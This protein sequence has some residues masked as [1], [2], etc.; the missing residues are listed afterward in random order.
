MPRASTLD[1]SFSHLYSSSS[2]LFVVYSRKNTGRMFSPTGGSFFCASA[3]VRFRYTDSG[4]TLIPAKDAKALSSAFLSAGATAPP[5][6]DVDDD[7]GDDGEDGADLDDGDDGDDGDDEPL[8]ADFVEV[9]ASAAFV[10]VGSGRTSSVSSSPVSAFLSRTAADDDD[11]D[12]AGDEMSAASKLRRSSSSVSVLRT[13]AST[14]ASDAM[15]NTVTT[16]PLPRIR[17][18]RDALG[19]AAPACAGGAAGNRSGSSITLS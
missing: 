15:N 13:L 17:E 8:D 12:E 7:D 5:A 18:K 16:V 2:S 10:N 14:S 9:G 6:A 11:D 4:G 1:C 3:G 19:E